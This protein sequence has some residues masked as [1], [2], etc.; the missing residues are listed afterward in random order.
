VGIARDR[1]SVYFPGM[2]ITRSLLRA[3][4]IAAWMLLNLQRLAN[5]RFRRRS[6]RALRA[7]SFFVPCDG[8]S[9]Q[10]LLR[11]DLI[12]RSARLSDPRWQTTTVLPRGFARSADASVRAFGTLPP[13]AGLTLVSGAGFGQYEVRST[14]P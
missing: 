5:A 2:M 10:P 1:G 11:A 8:R 9:I 3:R 6:L 13:A 4:L 14:W 12:D 7:E